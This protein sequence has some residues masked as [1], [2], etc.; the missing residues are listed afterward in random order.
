MV[1]LRSIYDEHAGLQDRFREAGILK[2]DLAEKLGAIGLVGRASG[3]GYDLRWT[4]RGHPTMSLQPKLV[5]QTAGDVAAR[6]Q[7]RFDEIVES[8]RL[9]RALLEILP[10]GPFRLTFLSRSQIALVLV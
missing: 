5:T 1:D 2:Q 9:C 7:V 10:P 3:I 8:L 4:I 6:V